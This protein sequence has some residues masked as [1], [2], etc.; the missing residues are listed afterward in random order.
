MLFK[1]YFSQ[2]VEAGSEVA[3]TTMDSVSSLI[4]NDSEYE[5]SQGRQEKAPVRFGWVSGV[6]VSEG[7][8]CVCLS[9]LQIQ[10]VEH[11]REC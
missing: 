11:G 4:I 8:A 9:A 1:L 6:M 5:E 10:A 3:N 2:E 7:R